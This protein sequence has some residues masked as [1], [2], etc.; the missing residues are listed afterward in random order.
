MRLVIGT[1]NPGK[2]AQ[3]A[4]A[5]SGS[6]FECVAISEIVDAV[7][8]VDEVG[9]S[10]TAIAERKALAYRDAVKGP[11]LSLDQWL[12]FDEA[13]P[14][15]QP[16]AHVRRIPGRPD[17]ATDDQLVDYYV[18]LCRWYGGRLTARWHLGVAVATEGGVN[19]ICIEA[20]RSLVTTP[21][22][23]RRPGLPLSCLQI[24]RA[25]G[26]YVSEHTD[27]EETELWQRAYGTELVEFV[28]RSLADVG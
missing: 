3:M 17:G 18:A 11:V 20:V 4:G 2:V 19:S 25:T 12:Y 9:E 13:Q 23:V 26:K 8:R 5:L 16:R 27:A 28:S 6:P 22:P 1:T 15:D 10:P 21:S 7:P 14:H 24:D